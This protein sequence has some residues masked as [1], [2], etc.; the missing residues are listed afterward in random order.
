MK[1]LNF[2]AQISVPV[3]NGWTDNEER[4]MYEQMVRA[5]IRTALDRTNAEH[6]EV[7]NVK[8]IKTAE[9]GD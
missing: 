2:Q 6:W 8:T 4:K 5:I 9:G 3:Q 7:K 1:R